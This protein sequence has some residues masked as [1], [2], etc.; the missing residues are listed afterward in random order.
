MTVHLLC[1]CAFSRGV[2]DRI[3]HAMGMDTQL[4]SL[5]EMWEAGRK[6]KRRKIST[7]FAKSRRS[8][9][10]IVS[11]ALWRTRNAS[12]F[13]GQRCYVENTWGDMVG[14][15]KAWGRHIGGTRTIS[16]TEGWFLIE[17]T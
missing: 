17:E 8:L 1:Q 10:S 12:I 15:I 6:T 4:S 11:W 9:V 3:E 7:V 13:R 16:L 5:E 2:W 14:F